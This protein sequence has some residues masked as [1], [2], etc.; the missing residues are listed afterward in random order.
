LGK[1]KFA[2]ELIEKRIKLISKNYSRELP[3]AGHALKQLKEI[4]KENFPELE[5]DFGAG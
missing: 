2:S 4:V 1:R 3:Y 5:A